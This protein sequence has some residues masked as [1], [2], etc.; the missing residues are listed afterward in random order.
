[1]T[2]P[3]WRL[4]RARLKALHPHLTKRE[5][6]TRHEHHTYWCDCGTTWRVPTGLPRDPRQESR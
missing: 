4:E 2:C 5:L 3:A 1:M 6:K